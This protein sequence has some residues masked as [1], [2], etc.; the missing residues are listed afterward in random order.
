M[1]LYLNNVNSDVFMNL[2]GESTLFFYKVSGL[3]CRKLYSSI[4]RGSYG[5]LIYEK[6]DLRKLFVKLAKLNGVPLCF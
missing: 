4:Y 1:K 6:K 5:K 3:R 2:Y